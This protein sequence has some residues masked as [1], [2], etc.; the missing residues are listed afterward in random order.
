MSAERRY[1]SQNAN[2]GMLC[3]EHP[4]VATVPFPFPFATYEAGYRG[5]TGFRSPRLMHSPPCNRHATSP[6]SHRRPPAFL[7]PR[8]AMDSCGVG[9]FSLNYG[10]QSVR[11]K[12]PYTPDPRLSRIVP[13][14]RDPYCPAPTTLHLAI[15]VP[16]SSHTRK[17][18]P[19]PGRLHL[20]YSHEF[21]VLTR[22][23]TNLP[24][25]T[26]RPLRPATACAIRMSP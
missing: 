13:T 18:R 7:G 22:S 12:S 2:P 4:G 5:P 16:R 21:H 10:P 23:V 20:W 25:L 6:A 19:H 1:R 26:T 8:R 24:H 14:T 9:A 15:T 17:Y 3:R 11:G